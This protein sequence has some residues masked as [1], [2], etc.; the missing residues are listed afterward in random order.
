M[1]NKQF[2]MKLMSFVTY[3]FPIDLS[4][5]GVCKFLLLGPRFYQQML[6]SLLQD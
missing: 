5:G 2:Y 6:G 4:Y 3:L 1:I